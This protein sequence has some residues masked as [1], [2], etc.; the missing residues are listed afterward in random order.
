[1]RPS[2]STLLRGAVLGALLMAGRE[3]RG[4]GRAAAGLPVF[5]SPDLTPQWRTPE[6]LRAAPAGR[7]PD[8]VLQDQFGERLTRRD[9][10]GRV[11][12]A[13]FFFTRCSGLCP[14]MRGSMSEVFSRLG[15]N[16]ELLLL[17]HS[18]TPEVDTVPVLAAYAKEHGI[19]GPRWRLLTGSASEI[20]KV[21]FQG[22]LVPHPRSDDEPALHSEMVVLLNRHQRVRGVYNS[23]LRTEVQFLEH[24]LRALLA[25]G[26]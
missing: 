23:T 22:Y 4:E 10:E 8:F 16:K 15:G 9:L 17:S 13:N 7:F 19:G 20:A 6:A 3:V 26:E 14:R 12:L 1:M 2:G 18:V 24:D 5:E 25:S 11:V 21:E